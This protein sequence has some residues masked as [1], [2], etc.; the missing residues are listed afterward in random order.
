MN[1]NNNVGLKAKL[2][3]AMGTLLFATA[4]VMADVLNPTIGSLLYEENFNTLDSSVWNS[5]E[6]D[7]CAIGLCGWGNQELQYYRANNLAI[8]NVPFEPATKAL[9]I[10][11][12]REAFGGSSFTSGKITTENKLQ[13]KYGMIEIRMSTPQV[14]VGLWPAAW[15]LGTSLATWPAKGE[16][17]IMEMGHRAQAMADA[18]F[19]GADINSYVG[20]NAIFY[21][22]A[23][24]V[25]ANPTCA[26]STA[27]QTDNAYVANTPLTNRF[28]KYR[29]YWTD[30]QIRFTVI[31]NG[32]ETDLYQNPI[33]VNEESSEFQAP[34]TCS[35][36]WL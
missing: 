6:G 22:S 35:L 25:P 23:A 17:D 26:A 15:M 14:G 31:D 21:A 34:F 16:I 1:I 30:S 3:A 8:E 24:C 18:G 9:A 19:L 2:T 20:S 12:K 28:V 10:Q 5:I 11:A 32:V 7:G 33:P 13:I 27:W 36:I 4:P 29:L